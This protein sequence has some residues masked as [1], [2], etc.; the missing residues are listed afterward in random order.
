MTIISTTVKEHAMKFEELK[1][2]V[3]KVKFELFTSFIQTNYLNQYVVCP[4][5]QWISSTFPEIARILRSFK[6]S[7]LH[8]PFLLH[9]ESNTVILSSILTLI[10]VLFEFRHVPSFFVLKIFF[11]MAILLAAGLWGNAN[12]NCARTWIVLCLKLCLYDKNIPF[13]CY[14]HF[15]FLFFVKF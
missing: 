7:R 15:E 1:I 5:A 4:M 2:L 8:L 3:T 13:L 12:L 11:W 6:L 10:L 14:Q 9:S